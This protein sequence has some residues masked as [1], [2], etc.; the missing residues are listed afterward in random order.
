FPR[1]SAQNPITKEEWRRW[2]KNK[3]GKNWKDFLNL[4]YDTYWSYRRNLRDRLNACCQKGKYASEQNQ[5]IVQ[6]VIEKEA[7]EKGIPAPP[8]RKNITPPKNKKASFPTRSSQTVLSPSNTINTT[9]NNNFQQSLSDE[10]SSS[11]ESDES[12]SPLINKQ[13]ASITLPNREFRSAPPMNESD[14]LTDND[15]NNTQWSF[16][17]IKDSNNN[18]TIEGSNN[19]N[20]IEDSNNN[21]TQ[22]SSGENIIEVDDNNNI[23]QSSGENIIEVDVEVDDNNDTQQSSGKKRPI[24][25]TRSTRSTTKKGSTEK[26]AVMY[27]ASDDDFILAQVITPY[28][29]QGRSLI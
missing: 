26:A 6:K 29:A 13:T 14:Y 22:Q 15:N 28:L 23:R 17:T 25:L 19:N 20:T 16:N 3:E 8:K 11:T 10:N 21:N 4:P 7:R 9:N 5:G 2:K 12:S 24:Q 27:L 1:G 18:N